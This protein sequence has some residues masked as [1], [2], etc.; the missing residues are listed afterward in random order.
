VLITGGIAGLSSSGSV[1]TAPMAGGGYIA[2][3][4]TDNG[5]INIDGITSENGT[6]S[7]E[8]R[9]ELEDKL[10][11][12]GYDGSFTIRA[13]DN[14][15]VQHASVQSSLKTL[16]LDADSMAEAVR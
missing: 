1:A 13:I 6:L 4:G 2:N 5:T 9:E 15:F 8:Q 10:D 16:G 12:L 14:V 11:E 7:P 3:T